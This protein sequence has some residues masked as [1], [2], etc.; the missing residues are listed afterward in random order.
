M[1]DSDG[2]HPDDPFGKDAF[3]PAPESPFDSAQEAFLEDRLTAF[4][5]FSYSGSE[6]HRSFNWHGEARFSPDGRF[7]YGFC[8]ETACFVVVDLV[9]STQLVFECVNLRKV[10]VLNFVLV[11]PVLVVVYGADAFWL[12]RLNPEKETCEWIQLQQH[13]P[14]TPAYVLT[15]IGGTQVDVRRAILCSNHAYQLR[16][17]RLDV[18]RG[19]LEEE[20]VEQLEDS[21]DVYDLEKKQWTKRSGNIEQAHW[22]RVP[23]PFLLQREVRHCVWS[24]ERVYF[25][26]YTYVN[27][28]RHSAVFCCDLER[29]EWRQ[30]SFTVTN[31]DRIS[32][33][34]NVKTG[35]QDG[36]L[37]VC[38]KGGDRVGIYRLLLRNP[39]PL[40]LLA[41]AALRTS[42][43]DVD[44]GWGFHGCMQ[45]TPYNRLLP[46]MYPN[47]TP[48]PRT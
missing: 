12:L 28:E 43:I 31:I 34:V 2:K 42:R 37:L 29:R 40:V 20:H 21:L 46:P 4:S 13:P 27:E 3:G 26:G 23:P 47:M 35:E 1:A 24:R 6:F 33:L 19:S 38:K 10:H 5:D 18:D 15:V 8:S 32:P 17:V 39:D 22:P 11:S 9:L 25:C 30:L 48:V 45:K 7:V 41:A 16:F 36:L 14:S 44:G